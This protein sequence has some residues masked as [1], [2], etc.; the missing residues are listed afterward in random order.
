M[1]D[2]KRTSS[3]ISAGSGNTGPKPRQLGDGWFDPA[4]HQLVSHRA[5]VRLTPAEVFLIQFLWHR[6]LVR[7]EA[8]LD[9][10]GAGRREPC[11]DTALKVIVHRLRRKMATVLTDARIENVWGHGYRLVGE[12]DMA[13]RCPHCGALIERKRK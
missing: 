10:Y 8:L 13:E 12:R 9:A 11:E 3:A 1:A 5:K 7:N 4:S 6:G 2:Q